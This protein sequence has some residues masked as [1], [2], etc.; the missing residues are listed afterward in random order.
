MWRTSSSLRVTELPRPAEE[1]PLVSEISHEEFTFVSFSLNFL[2]AERME[3]ENLIMNSRAAGL[4]LLV[5][6][7]ISALLTAGLLL[8]S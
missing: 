5:F 8:P 6:P 3:E 1:T 2:S 7:E 4:S